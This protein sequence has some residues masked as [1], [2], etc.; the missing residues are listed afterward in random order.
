MV[1]PETRQQWFFRHLPRREVSQVKALVLPEGSAGFGGWWVAPLPSQMFEV[2][3]AQGGFIAEELGSSCK[4]ESTWIKQ[5]LLPGAQ[6]QTP[7]RGTFQTPQADPGPSG[8]RCFIMKTAKISSQPLGITFH[9]SKLPV[10]RGVAARQRGKFCAFSGVAVPHC[11]SWEGFLH[12]CPVVYPTLPPDRSWEGLEKLSAASLLVPNQHLCV[13]DVTGVKSCQW[14]ECPP[15]A[16]RSSQAGCCA[17]AP[18]KS[19]SILFICLNVRAGR[20]PST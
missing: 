18:H 15:V 8:A 14:S 20:I 9:S 17:Q 7:E 4:A 5:R 6:S 16:P 11:W 19:Q 2:S 10:C 12:L 1:Q 3:P 13:A